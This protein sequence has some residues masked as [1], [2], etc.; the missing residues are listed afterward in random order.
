MLGSPLLALFTYFVVA[1]T[2]SKPH[3][4]LK[5]RRLLRIHNIRWCAKAQVRSLSKY[6]QPA[7]NKWNDRQG[8][9]SQRCDDA[10]GWEE[11]GGI[12]SPKQ[13]RSSAKQAYVPLRQA[14]AGT[15]QHDLSTRPRDRRRTNRNHW[16]PQRREPSCQAPD[17][18]L[19]K[20]QGTFE[21]R[22]LLTSSSDY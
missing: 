11:Q 3:A 17:M 16:P 18:H 6:R 12:R 22:A 8:Q 10:H 21:V 9:E 14:S 13:S 20:S 19:W 2:N 1:T 7:A 5:H 4:P 15:S